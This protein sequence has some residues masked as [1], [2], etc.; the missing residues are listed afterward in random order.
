MIVKSLLNIPKGLISL[1][2]ILIVLFILLLCLITRGFNSVFICLL[3]VFNKEEVDKY[4]EIR[5]QKLIE[6]CKYVIELCIKQ[7]CKYD[8]LTVNSFDAE[9]KLIGTII[10]KKEE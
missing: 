7:I 6:S 1:S 10:F 8:D 3:N 9:G 2:A 4:K 5:K